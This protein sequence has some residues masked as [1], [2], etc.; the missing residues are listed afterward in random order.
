VECLPV[1]HAQIERY[2]EW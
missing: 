1:G 2:C